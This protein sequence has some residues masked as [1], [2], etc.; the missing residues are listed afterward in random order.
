MAWSTAITAGARA[1]A[2]RGMVALRYTRHFPLDRHAS[3]RQALTGSLAQGSG[4]GRR[5]DAD[6][7]R[8]RAGL[9]SWAPGETAQGSRRHAGG[10]GGGADGVGRGGGR[11]AGT[12]LVAL[13]GVWVTKGC[14]A[15]KG[16][17]AY[18][19]ALAGE[20]RVL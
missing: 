14:G 18:P 16:L 12:V 20:R 5:T 19:R 3:Q 17:T 13:G 11:P 2:S 4:E 7:F 8:R 10:S 15:F 1:A 9:R 6:Q